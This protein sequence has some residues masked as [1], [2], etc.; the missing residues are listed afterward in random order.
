MKQSVA[1]GDADKYEMTNGEASVLNR[2][3]CV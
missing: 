3:A 2:L 1:E